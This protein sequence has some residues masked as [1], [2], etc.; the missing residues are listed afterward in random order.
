MKE[1][2]SN[3]FP[4]AIFF[5][6]IDGRLIKP[7]Q[8]VDLYNSVESKAKIGRVLTSAEIGCALSHIEIYKKIILQKKKYALILEDDVVL[9][10]DFKLVCAAAVEHLTDPDIIF[11]GSHTSS[12]R[13]KDVFLKIWGKMEISSGRHIGFPAEPPYGAYGYLLSREAAIKM[14]NIVS[15]L[16][17][18]IDHY[19][20]NSAL[21]DIKVV[22]PSVVRV[23]SKLESL[24][25]LNADRHRLHQSKLRVSDKNRKRKNVVIA[26]GL[27]P[28]Y[29]A[30]IKKI[31]IFINIINPI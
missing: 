6:A 11:L 19:T 29:K 27:Y 8:K 30:S 31:R 2:L 7:S 22:K 4:S 5:D 16:Y 14:L 1:L 28:F 18:P 12:N 23:S 26:L 13:H 10:P 17:L 21:L 25:N 3:F 20:S 9:E 15:D 24:S